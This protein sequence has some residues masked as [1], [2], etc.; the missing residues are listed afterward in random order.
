[1]KLVRMHLSPYCSY[2]SRH[3]ITQLHMMIYHV[4]RWH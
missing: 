4:L 2:K 3:Y 1:M